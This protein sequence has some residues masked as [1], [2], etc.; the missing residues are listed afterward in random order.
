MAT[1]FICNLQ[2]NNFNF[3]N[4]KFERLS[5]DIENNPEKQFPKQHNI[6]FKAV[7]DEALDV[8][9]IIRE[10]GLI[11][12]VDDICLLLS[13]PLSSYVYC[14]ELTINGA[15]EKRGVLRVADGVGALMVDQRKIEPFLNTAAKSLRK[16]DWAAKTR[17]VD[18]ISFLRGASCSGFVDVAFMLSWIALEILANA[19]A[20]DRRFKTILS[21]NTFNKKVKPPINRALDEIDKANLPEEQKKLIKDKLSELNHPS[22]IRKVRKLR[23]AYEW[24]FMT[25]Q[26]IDDCYKCRNSFMHEGTYAVFNQRTL[27][28]LRTRFKE[29]IQLALLYLLGCSDYVFDLE[30]KKIKIRGN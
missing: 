5:N 6:T 19:Y 16:P 13:L 30:N 21:K 20:S 7:A 3:E 8:K 28:D 22:I 27:I 17:I 10:N 4:V 12:V 1:F 18:S 9:P 15:L 25:D 29:S 24:D 26:L 14:Y 2:T 23:D 11:G